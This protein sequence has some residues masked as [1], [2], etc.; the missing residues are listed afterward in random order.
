METLK[1][2]YNTCKS[3]LCEIGKKYDT[4]KS[5]QRNNV[6]DSRHCHPYTLF[7]EELFK[8]K[9]NE[10]LKIAELG[11]LYTHSLVMWKEYFI[12]SQIYGYLI[13]SFKNKFNNDRITLSNINVTNKDSIIN[14]FNKINTHYDI[15]IE[16]TTH[17]FED[18]IRVI[19]NVYQYLKP[20]GILIVEDIFKSYNENDYINRLK[21]VLDK[22]QDYYFV[23]LDHINRNSTGW[24]NDKLFILV[25][26]GDDPIFK[27][28]NKLTIITPS[29]RINNLLQIKNSI[30]FHY[31]D[32]W[33]IVYDG[34]KIT[35]NPNLFENKENKENNKIKEYLYKGEGVY[36]NP[37]RNYA[38]SKITNPNALLYYLDDDNIIHSNLY[39]LLNIVVDNTK[40]YT[41]NQLR[42][43]D[44]RLRLRAEAEHL[45]S[46]VI[47][48]YNQYKKMKGNNININYIDSAMV[49]IPYSLCKD[50]KWILDKYEADGYYIKKCYKKCKDKH[51][52]IDNYLCYYNKIALKL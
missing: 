20:G 22:F 28:T 35:E 14:A 5:S 37:Q 40:M 13:N 38:L 50:I 46:F 45:K 8:N 52:F 41:F 21:H 6:T 3:E 17:Q 43:Q 9:K 18:Q 25:K 26:G 32:E 27:N 42:Y 23:E 12:N 49:I 34:S 4:D 39:R 11:K 16:D 48:P 7:Y 47:N 2:N 51:V 29:Y 19:E 10:K 1:I 36:G 33:I 44:D 15:I 31:I 24:D 30:N